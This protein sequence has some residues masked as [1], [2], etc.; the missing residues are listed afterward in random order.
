[1][2]AIQIRHHYEENAMQILPFNSSPS[3]VT[4]RKDADHDA[5]Y[6]PCPIFESTHA[7]ESE[8]IASDDK[9]FFNRKEIVLIPHQPPPQNSQDCNSNEIEP[10]DQDQDQQQQRIALACLSE[11]IS[12]FGGEGLDIAAAATPATKRSQPTQP[13]TPCVVV[14]KHQHDKSPLQQQR[15]QDKPVASPTVQRRSLFDFSIYQSTQGDAD[16]YNK[17]PCS[18]GTSGTEES[19]MNRV[20][21]TPGFYPRPEPGKSLLK[22]SDSATG[23]LKRT[24]SNVS[25]SNLEIREY[26]VALS[27]HP[28]CSYGP[29]IQLGWIYCEQAPV[30]VD[31]YEQNRCP[32]STGQQLLLP[33][34]VRRDLLLEEGGYTKQELQSAWQEVERVKRERQMSDSIRR[35][36]QPNEGIGELFRHLRNWIFQTYKRQ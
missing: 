29:P 31:D 14:P 10:E 35:T 22:R 7:Y 12:V 15:A 36:S 33:Y 23:S 19:H 5:V 2:N 3:S 13:R 28:D 34:P 16:F 6:K 18:E 30:S 25:F 17:D 9:S 24:G 21:S 8:R 32:R 11:L 27:D 1:M 4:T 20:H 26:N